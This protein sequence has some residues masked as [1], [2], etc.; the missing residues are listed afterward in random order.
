MGIMLAGGAS[1]RMGEDKAL[2]A[3]GGRPMARWV[4]TALGEVCRRTAAIGRS[5]TLEGIEAIPD[6]G[7]PRRGPL[8]GLVTAL[9]TFSSPILLVGVDQPLVRVE[10]LRALANLAADGQTAVCIDEVEQVTCAAYQADLLSAARAHLESG[11]SVR[12]LLA[13]QPHTRIDPDEWR[14]W[15]EDGR[16]W[17]SMDDR[18]AIVE[19]ERRFRVSLLD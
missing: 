10:T 2:V 12:T 3:V 19:A 6:V 18:S 14:G 13:S 15:G 16:S 11:G 7:D 5:G 17:F 4:A 8:S 9:A 1:R